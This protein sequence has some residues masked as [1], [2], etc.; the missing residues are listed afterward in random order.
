MMKF[1]KKVTQEIL[2]RL[3]L[4]FIALVYALSW[5]VLGISLYNFS[6]S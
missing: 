2:K 6:G 4:I 3:E 1:F 5:V